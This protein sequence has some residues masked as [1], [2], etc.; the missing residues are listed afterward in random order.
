MTADVLA[1]YK[2]VYLFPWFSH[3]EFII[4]FIRLLRFIISA[5][6]LF[7]I[8]RSPGKI[9]RGILLS[10]S[11]EEGTIERVLNTFFNQ[12]FIFAVNLR[13]SLFPRENR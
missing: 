2:E 10:C 12:I 5:G 3:V 13:F 1:A 4:I 6:M 11:I 8:I 9:Y 7:I